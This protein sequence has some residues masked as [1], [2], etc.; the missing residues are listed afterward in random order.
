MQIHNI[1]RLLRQHPIWPRMHEANRA[2]R[3]RRQ[4]PYEYIGGPPRLVIGAR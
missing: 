3:V 2:L 1:L 4:I